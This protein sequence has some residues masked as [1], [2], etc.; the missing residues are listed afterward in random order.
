MEIKIKHRKTEKEFYKNFL[1][2][3]DNIYHYFGEFRTKKEFIEKYNLEA[4]NLNGHVIGVPEDI[5]K[6]GEDNK[7]GT[8]LAIF[9]NKPNSDELKFIIVM[10]SRVYITNKGQTVDAIVA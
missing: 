9:Y 5:W 3:G 7:G 1:F 4:R 6:E 10:N 2:E 8:F